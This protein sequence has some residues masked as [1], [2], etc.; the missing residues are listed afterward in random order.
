[1][2]HNSDLKALARLDELCSACDLVA[3]A[4]MARAMCWFEACMSS[5]DGL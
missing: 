1:M 3:L 5:K 4:F 2:L